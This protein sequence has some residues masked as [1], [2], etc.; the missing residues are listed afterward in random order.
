MHAV[1]QKYFDIYEQRDAC[2]EV[3]VY[4]VIALSQ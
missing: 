1:L 2:Y 4:Q 3:T